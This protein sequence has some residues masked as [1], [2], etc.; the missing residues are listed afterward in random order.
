MNDLVQQTGMINFW[1]SVRE[2]LFLLEHGKRALSKSTT[3]V[4]CTAVVGDIMTDT[5]I[6]P[7]ILKTK[8]GQGQILEELHN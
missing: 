4:I 7:H 3:A 6:E 1:K 2:Q 8:L 5:D